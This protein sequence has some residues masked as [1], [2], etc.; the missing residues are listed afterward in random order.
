[1]NFRNT[2]KFSDNGEL[3]VLCSEH[4]IDV[5]FIIHLYNVRR[6][7]IHICLIFYN[8]WL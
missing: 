2:L 1:M 3:V 7:H 8:R 5:K 6:F 4:V